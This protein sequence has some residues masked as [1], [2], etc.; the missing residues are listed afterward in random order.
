[1][2]INRTIIYKDKCKYQQQLNNNRGTNKSPNLDETMRPSDNQYKN[3]KRTC[4]IVDFTVPVD[5]RGKL[6]ESGTRNKYLHLA[7]KLKNKTMEH[8]ADGDTYC[9]LCTWSNHQRVGNATGILGNERINGDH[10]DSIITKNDQ[11]TEMSPGDLK[12]LAITRTP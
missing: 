1:M 4:R 3:T 12:R 11:D 8:E 10:P 6:K 7:R 9:K 2:E 5:K